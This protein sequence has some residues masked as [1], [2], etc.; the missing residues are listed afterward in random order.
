VRSA[1]GSAE[2]ETLARQL[3]G[4]IY[5]VTNQ[6][7]GRG[8]FVGGRVKLAL[9]ADGSIA[10]D[11]SN[12]VATPSPLGDAGVDGGESVSRRG[13]WSVVLL[14]GAPMVQ[15]RWQGTGSSY[16]LTRYFTIRPDPSGQS[17]EVDGKRLPMTGRC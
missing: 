10:Y 7:S 8:A 13:Q 11:A 16:S 17:A 4:R 3:V 6:A 1:D 9:C 12:L 5:S 15:A 14:A 2:A